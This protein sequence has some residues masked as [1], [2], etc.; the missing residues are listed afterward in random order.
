MIVDYLP[1]DTENIKKSPDLFSINLLGE[2][3]NFKISWNIVEN[4]F[5][6]DLF[7]IDGD[8][9]VQG[10]RI[11]YGEDLLENITNEKL[12]E[13]LKILVLDFTG[14]NQNVTYENFMGD[15]KPY[16]FTS[17]VNG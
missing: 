16:I 11:V 10:K 8:I 3:L 14:E 13:A 1:V 4:A 2:R 17:D 15:V 5:Y 6:F 7:H 9:I 12:P